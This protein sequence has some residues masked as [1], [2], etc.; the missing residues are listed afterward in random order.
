[1]HLL[2]RVACDLRLILRRPPRMQYA[3]LC[4]RMREGRPLEVL[5]I[6]SRDTGRWG[7][8]ERVADEGQER[9]RGGCAGGLRGSGR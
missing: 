6:G 7:H 5:L 4:Y 2:H 3:A 9:A 1:M 8:S